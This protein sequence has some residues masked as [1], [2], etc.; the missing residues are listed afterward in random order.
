[1]KIQ[2]TNKQNVYF[3][4][5]PHYDHTALVRGVT[6]WENSSFCRDFDTLEEHNQ[7]L[8]D[9]INN[10]V[11]EDDILFCLGDW[12][13]GNYKNR[14]NVENIRRFR[15]R[16]NCK[17]IHLI[18]GNHDDEI[19]KNVL[20]A[21]GVTRTQDMFTSVREKI[22][23]L[24]IV[25]QPTIQGAKA[26]KQIITLCHYAF[27][28]WDKGHHGAWM[29]Y[30]H[31]H[32]TLD[33]MTP[34]I[35]NPTW[36]GDGFFYK[37]YR[38]M[39]V[40]FDCHPEFRPY[41]YQEIKAIMERRAVELEVDH[42]VGYEKPVLSYRDTLSNTKKSLNDTKSMVIG[43]MFMGDVDSFQLITEVNDDGTLDTI[44][45]TKFGAIHES[46]DIPQSFGKYALFPGGRNMV[47]ML[48]EPILWSN[49]IDKLID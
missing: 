42:H 2:I 26:T 22:D 44:E 32:N 46:F 29:L 11:G 6:T 30:G 10:T 25:E 18:T 19:L 35:A 45:I 20:F 4:S 48:N 15:E 36:I 33:G 23:N 5:D 38:T 31:S 43:I 40:G 13:F 14:D 34:T 12:S 3:C 39:D 47:D 16:I 1:M 49:F 7:Q 9:N 41:S 17:T 37:N 21:D 27:R 24:V 8:V 28:V